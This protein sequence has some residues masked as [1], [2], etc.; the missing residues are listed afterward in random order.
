MNLFGLVGLALLA[1][2]VLAPRKYELVVDTYENASLTPILTHV[3]R[4]KDAAQ[5]EAVR[6]AHLRY[7]SFFAGC[8][9]GRFQGQSGGFACRNAVRSAGFVR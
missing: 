2:K 1:S 8:Q 7:D 5:A 6:A 3:F 4:G 9:R